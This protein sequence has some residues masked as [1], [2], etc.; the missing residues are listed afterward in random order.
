VKTN[1][2][3]S[4][5]QPLPVAADPDAAHRV[6]E[7]LRWARVNRF[8]KPNP[9]KTETELNKGLAI[10]LQADGDEPSITVR[11]AEVDGTVWADRTGRDAL[12]A[13]SRDVFETF[14][15]GPDQLRRKKPL[16]VKSWKID[17]LEVDLA[18]TAR[19]YVKADGSWQRDG[20]PVEGEEQTALQDY[21]R[22]LE[23]TE[24]E[25][26][27]DEP[28]PPTHYGL[29]NPVLVVTTVDTNGGEQSLVV[30]EEDGRVFARGGDSGPVYQMPANYLDKGRSLVGRN[31]LPKSQGE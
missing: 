21:L 23:S 14:H 18:A 19:I 10:V 29:D 27:I 4:L 8:L 12:F 17:R 24:A 31:D 26:V 22:S 15:V 1:G 5:E 2:T 9:E 16:L 13:V 30:G 7:K 20:E 3:W 11:M 28:G 6:A 25:Q